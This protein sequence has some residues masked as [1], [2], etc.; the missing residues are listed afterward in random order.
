[1]LL[2]ASLANIL[3]T[4]VVWL[5]LDKAGPE[6]G[7]ALR[8]AGDATQAIVAIVLAYLIGSMVIGFFGPIKHLRTLLGSSAETSA[9]H[10]GTK[11]EPMQA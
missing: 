4:G 6:V 7:S 10:G 8:V 9:K 2:P 3:V 11:S 5:A 1:V